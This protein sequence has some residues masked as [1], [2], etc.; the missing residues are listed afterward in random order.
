MHKSL[1]YIS[2]ASPG[3]PQVLT[4]NETIPAA[5]YAVYS[6]LVEVLSTNTGNIYIGE[7]NM[8]K[9]T[10]AGLFAVLPP[11][12]ANSYPAF[13]AVVAEAPAAFTLNNIYIDADDPG[14]GVLC[15]AVQV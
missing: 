12:T 8:N 10:G 4:K 1:G 14:D 9:T 7:A 11:P 6:Y 13:T 15:S 2:V 5:N 3:T